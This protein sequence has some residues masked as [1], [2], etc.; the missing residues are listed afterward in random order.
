MK[1]NIHHCTPFTSIFNDWIRQELNESQPPF[2]RHF[3]RSLSRA[4][5]PVQVSL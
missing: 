1:T 4:L 3:G 5:N 2:V